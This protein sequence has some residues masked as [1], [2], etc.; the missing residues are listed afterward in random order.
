M[1]LGDT[2]PSLPTEQRICQNCNL[3]T[4][5]DEKHF[6]VN[7]PK[8]SIPIKELFVKINSISKSDITILNDEDKFYSLMNYNFNN[9]DI[10]THVLKFINT[11]SFLLRNGIQ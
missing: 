11:S 1:R 3:N 7:C 4:T 9:N 2:G 8:Y 5:E 6:I 10:S